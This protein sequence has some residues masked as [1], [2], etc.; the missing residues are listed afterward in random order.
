[1]VDNI[2]RGLTPRQPA[3][4]QGGTPRGNVAIRQLQRQPPFEN[5][6]GVFFV[7]HS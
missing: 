2:K 1:M 4:E 6:L 3:A 5:Q 7:W